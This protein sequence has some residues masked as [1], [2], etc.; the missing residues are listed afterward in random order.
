MPLGGP[1]LTTEDGKKNGVGGRV[2]ERR[3]ALNITQ[4]ALCAR[5]AALT[6][7]LPIQWN[8]TVHEIY[9]LETGKRICGDLE[10]KILCKA[11]ECSLLWLMGE[12][13][14]PLP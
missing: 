7:N 5:L 8:P 11:L 10:A 2:K 3:N 4:D 13:E 1:R 9:K 14:Q 6:K 12:D